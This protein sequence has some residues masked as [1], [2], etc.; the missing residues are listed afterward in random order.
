MI[1]EGRN[2]EKKET[3]K[4]PSTYA[5]VRFGS[6][7][8]DILPREL[9]SIA[10]DNYESFALGLHGPDLLFYYR[11][12]ERTDISAKGYALHEKQ[13]ADFFKKA[14]EIFKARGEKT[15]ERAYLFGFL[16]H[17][18]LDSS[19][20][21]IVNAEMKAKGF[22]HTE[23]EAAFERYLY[24]TDGREPYKC[25]TTEH[26]MNCARTRGEASAYFG[27]TEKQAEK[28]IKSIKFYN[29]LMC[30]KTAVGRAVVR[31][32]AGNSE[33]TREIRGMLVPK[34][35]KPEFADAIDGL[36]MAYCDGLNKAAELI[37]NYN[38]YLNGEGELSALLNRNYE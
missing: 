12:L 21:P 13:A 20:H 14:A 28:A 2:G 32:L 5:H 17:F 11:P 16:C 34:F 8:T 3:K 23:I 1:Q 25:D 4:M 36:R 7:V 33:K 30:A 18:A 26:I 15:Y 19:S 22:A 24:D 29:R 37:L 31:A 10:N 9:R 38:S 6:D 35:V 27:I